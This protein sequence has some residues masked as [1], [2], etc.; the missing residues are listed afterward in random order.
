VA[1]NIGGEVRSFVKQNRLGVSGGS[2]W[3]FTL[4]SN[5]DTVRA[6]DV[7]FVRAERIPAEGIPPGFWPG[8][9]DL[10]GEVLSPSD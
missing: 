1:A 10:A 9:P 2:D 6:P 4:A 3:G 7:G 5:P 8:A